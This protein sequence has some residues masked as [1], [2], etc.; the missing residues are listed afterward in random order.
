MNIFLN[1]VMNSNIKNCNSGKHKMAK[2][3]TYTPR[4]I[5]GLRYSVITVSIII[6]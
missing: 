5:V 6:H 4:G 2:L 3:Q 1:D